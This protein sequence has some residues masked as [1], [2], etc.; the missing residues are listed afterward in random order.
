MY[1]PSSPTL[2]VC[3]PASFYKTHKITP[4]PISFLR[5][6]PSSPPLCLCPSLLCFPLPH[7]KG[8]PHPSPTQS[9]RHCFSICLSS[10]QWPV[11]SFH[12]SC[13]YF[14]CSLIIYAPNPPL[15]L[16]FF[17]AL[18]YFC[19]FSSSLMISEIWFCLSLFASAGF[20][21]HLTNAPSHILYYKQ[22]RFQEDFVSV[23]CLLF[24]PQFV[25]LNSLFAISFVWML[26]DKP[27][28][29]EHVAFRSEA[30]VRAIKFAW[31]WI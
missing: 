4:T 7:P 28:M 23:I 29:W 8:T 16:L 10:S 30:Y 21:M 5:W 19:L 25:L 27:Q 17:S 26:S 9:L 22:L 6:P 18:C 24:V 12:F 2:Q 1:H 14:D 20:L 31:Q 3:S 13:V 11:T 15:V